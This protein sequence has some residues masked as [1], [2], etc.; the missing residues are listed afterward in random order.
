M[1]SAWRRGCVRTDARPERETFVP[2]WVFRVV[3]PALYHRMRRAPVVGRVFS[4]AF[5]ALVPRRGLVLVRVRRGPLDG[6]VLEVDPRTQIDAVVGDYERGVVETVSDVLRA[7]DTAFDIGAH[8]GYFTLLMATRVGEGGKVVAFEP[9][10]VVM[11]GLDRN[12]KRNGA[13]AGAGIVLVPAAVDARPGRV[14][15]VEGRETSRGRLVDTT[16]DLEVEVMTLDDLVLQFGSPRLVKIDV[17]GRETG[18]L[19]GAPETLAE[20][21]PVFVIEAHGEALEAECRALLE[22]RGYACEVTREPGRAET[23][24]VGRPRS[25]PSR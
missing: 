22:E 13:Q 24:L 1:P 16:G 7:G 4:R 2:A 5:D 18:V 3:P 11:E 23:Y 19:R 8:L 25:L 15:F 14:G 10:P 17:E 21:R 20:A 9:D 6:M 12:V